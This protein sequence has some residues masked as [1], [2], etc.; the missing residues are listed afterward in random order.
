MVLHGASWYI[1]VHHGASRCIMVHQSTSWYIM[2][3]VSQIVIEAVG[4]FSK[5]IA[6]RH[7]VRQS[8]ASMVLSSIMVH[9][10]TSWLARIRLAQSAHFRND[11][12][13]GN[14]RCP[15]FSP[16]MESRPSSA[17]VTV[18]P[19]S[20]VRHQSGRWSAITG[21]NSSQGRIGDGSTGGQRNWSDHGGTS[22]GNW[23]LVRFYLCI[24]IR[25]LM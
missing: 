13:S 14:R 25:R 21:H 11:I 5:H 18:R 22:W 1:M 6:G 3:S 15:W 19:R 2:A 20:F 8:A 16:G 7:F 23:G 17:A 4:T 9:L 24:T 12:S 10:G